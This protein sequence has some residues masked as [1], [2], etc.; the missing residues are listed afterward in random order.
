LGVKSRII[1]VAR[2]DFFLRGI[3]EKQSFACFWL[4]PSRN[5]LLVLV[6]V[7]LANLLPSTAGSTVLAGTNLPLKIDS[8][9]LA[10]GA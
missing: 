5:R 3:P 8:G 9:L 1:F 7:V 10:A 6:D 4:I 2:A